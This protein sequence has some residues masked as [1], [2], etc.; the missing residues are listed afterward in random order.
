MGGMYSP[1][2]P[3]RSNSSRISMCSLVFS[4]ISLRIHKG[5]KNSVIME[6]LKTTIKKKF[7]ADYN[8]KRQTETDE[9]II[10]L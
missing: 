7:R 2:L 4:I 8:N 10:G 3:F 5:N 1:Q 6:Y 9:L